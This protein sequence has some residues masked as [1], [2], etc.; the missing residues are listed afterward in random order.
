[1]MLVDLSLRMKKFKAWSEGSKD[2]E[3]LFCPGLPGAGKT[4]LASIVINKLRKAQEKQNSAVTFLYFSY[5]LQAEQTPIHMLRTLLW[6]LIDTLPSIP[7]EVTEFY[8]ANQ[9][10][11][12]HKTFKILS[13]VI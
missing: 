10:P 6:Q 12:Q 13:G 8:C 9:F 7:S 1:M 11:S 3:T 5:N 2:V 4:T